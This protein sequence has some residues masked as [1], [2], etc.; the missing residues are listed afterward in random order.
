MKRFLAALAFAA[1]LPIAAL[2]A[3]DNVDPQT[4]LCVTAANGRLCSTVLRFTVK[5]LESGDAPILNLLVHK[6]GGIG[7]TVASIARSAAAD[8]VQDIT[9]NWV[10]RQHEHL[11][12]VIDSGNVIRVLKY[13]H[14]EDRA[15]TFF[16]YPAADAGHYG[17]VWRAIPS[18]GSWI[19]NYLYFA[20]VGGVQTP[21][22]T[23]DPN[24][25]QLFTHVAAD[26]VAL[27]GQTAFNERVAGISPSVYISPTGHWNY[28]TYQQTCYVK[29]N[30]TVNTGLAWQVYVDPVYTPDG[31][32]TRGG[33]YF[34]ESFGRE[35]QDCGSATMLAG[36]GN[37][38]AAYAAS[39][40]SGA[41][42]GATKQ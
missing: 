39:G 37:D 29:E 13:T 24:Y 9:V 7:Q 4:P 28:G 36:V 6:D 12:D 42:Y 32:L 5:K 30:T 33:W 16:A 22:W 20:T 1:L 3:P 8:I 41:V 25:G 2:A 40:I 19:Y 31:T 34:G 35:F 10:D 15:L 26:T 21:Q 38:A 27:M 14:G 17:R 23:S 11:L 18:G